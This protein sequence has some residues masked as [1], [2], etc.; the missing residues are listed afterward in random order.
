M[1]KLLPALLLSY[2]LSA[3]TFGGCSEPISPGGVE[4]TT[5]VSGE[6]QETMED[7]QTENSFNTE[8]QAFE[9][10]TTKNRTMRQLLISHV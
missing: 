7:N 1:N 6:N 4:N 2:I 9:L 8:V 3:F 5:P 10:I